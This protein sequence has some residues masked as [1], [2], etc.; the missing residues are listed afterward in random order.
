[1][2]L[3]GALRADGGGRMTVVPVDVLAVGAH[4]DDVELGC[5][6]TVATLVAKGRSVGILDL[7][8]GEMGTRGTPELRAGEAA[9]AARILGAAFRETLDLRDGGL[10]TDREAELQVIDVIRRSRP[11]LILSM[12]PSE[13]HPDHARASRLVTDASFYAGLRALET[14][15]PA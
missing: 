2:R 1:R 7:T 5:G 8:R 10:R 6:A 14:G 3:V 4:P 13:R 12:P 9:E 11:K 15:S